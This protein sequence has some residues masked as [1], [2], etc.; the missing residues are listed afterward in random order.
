[1]VTAVLLQQQNLQMTIN[2]SSGPGL[3]SLE[4][5]TRPYANVSYEKQLD[6]VFSVVLP[7]NARDTIKHSFS[8]QRIRMKLG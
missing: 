5:Q 1:M 7:M 6:Q 4:F 8:A 3:V 2:L